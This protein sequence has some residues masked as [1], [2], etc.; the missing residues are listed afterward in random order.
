MTSVPDLDELAAPDPGDWVS[1]DA[2]SWK[3]DFLLF[4]LGV[5]LI[6]AF[7][8]LNLYS[9]PLGTVDVGTV[10]ESAEGIYGSDIEVYATLSHSNEQEFVLA[11]GGSNLFLDVVW[12]GD[13]QLPLNGTMVVATGHLIRSSAGPALMCD[14]LSVPN[15]I[16]TTYG[17]PWVLPSLRILFSVLVW[18]SVMIFSTGI[19]AVRHLHR[20]TDEE[21]HLIT[22]FAEMGAVT[23]GI[24]TAIIIAIVSSEPALSDSAGALTY[25]AAA[26]FAFLMTFALLHSSKRPD[27]RFIGNSM[28]MLA[29]IALLLGV[30][31]S[32]FSAQFESAVTVVSESARHFGDSAL[33]C[34][35]G[36]SGLIF[37]TAYAVRRRSEL[38]EVE[39]M[40]A[41]GEKR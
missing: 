9:L 24:L 41:A 27:L 6:L 34:A 10:F 17:N 8:F 2:P 4:I 40:I 20:Q 36:I 37:M 19:L 12:L 13:T 5:S 35:I 16:I 29:A 23:S 1:E 3:L 31:L 33:A 25:C 22:A 28:P 26:A 21:K 15:A 30:M 38:S 39:G 11:D 32:L 7:T 14:S 18:S